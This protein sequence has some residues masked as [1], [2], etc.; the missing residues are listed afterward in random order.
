MAGIGP[1]MNGFL[2]TKEAIERLAN[3]IYSGDGSARI[4]PNRYSN[5]LLPFFI[6]YRTIQAKVRTP[7]FQPIFFPAE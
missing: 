4:P 7:S 1:W 2:E 6:L 5:H 3:E